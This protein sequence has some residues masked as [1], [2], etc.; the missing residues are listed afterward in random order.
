MSGAL[1]VVQDGQQKRASPSECVEQ[2]YPVPRFLGGR[3]CDSE[4]YSEESDR[5]VTVDLLAGRE[6]V[7]RRWREHCVGYHDKEA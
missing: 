1:L 4:P 2:K 7:Y 3:A 6:S 5:T